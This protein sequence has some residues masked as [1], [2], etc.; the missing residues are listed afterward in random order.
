MYNT[1]RQE[2]HAIDI[3]DRDHLY[4]CQK[5]TCTKYFDILII[6]NEA[7]Q[8]NAYTHMI[9]FFK[10]LRGSEAMMPDEGFIANLMQSFMSN[11][12]LYEMY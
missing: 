9:L 8:I 10:P 12:V 3:R 6:W 2:C 1:Q 11:H 4:L 5:N 7:E